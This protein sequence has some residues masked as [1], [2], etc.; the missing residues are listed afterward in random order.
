MSPDDR[1]RIGELAA[2]HLPTGTIPFT[3]ILRTAVRDFGVE[4]LRHPGESIE[5]T[6]AR[7][8]EAFVEAEAALMASFEWWNR[9]TRVR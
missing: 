1:D 8:E 4:P 5:D 9:E 3:A 2:A 6:R 7:T